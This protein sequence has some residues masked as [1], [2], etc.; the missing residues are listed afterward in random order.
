[1]TM[2]KDERVEIAN[3]VLRSFAPG[4]TLR[5]ESGYVLVEWSAR[6]GTFTDQHSKRWMT[7]GQDFYP[8]WHRKWGHGGTSCTALAQLVRWIQCKPVLPI[9]TWQY[10]SGDKCRLL[11]HGTGE[12]VL[13]SLLDAGYPAKAECVLCGEAITGGMDWW[14][15]KGVSGP[16]CGMRSGCEQKGKQ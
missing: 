1:M 7:R 11:R 8:V 13:Q 16:C 3:E 9:G 4:T 5:L 2:C 12:N 10:W 15:L 6:S 14:S